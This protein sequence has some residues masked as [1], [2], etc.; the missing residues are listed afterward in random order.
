MLKSLTD[1]FYLI[2]NALLVPVLIVLLALLGWTLLLFGGFIRESICRRRVRQSLEKA[3]DASHSGQDCWKPLGYARSGL[4]SRFM[5]HVG[6]GIA[7]PNVIHRAL[8]LLENDITD[9][10]AR[11]TFITRVSPMFGLM[12]TLIPLGPALSGLASGNMQALAGNLVVV[13]TATVIGLLVSGFCFGMGL[14]RR[15]WYSR[16]LLDLEAVFSTVPTKEEDSE[17]DA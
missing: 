5:R 1:I 17:H 4:P 13:F 16:D 2:S 12:A 15:A 6:T 7:D 8:I 11:H 3:L 10:L 14:A 9:I